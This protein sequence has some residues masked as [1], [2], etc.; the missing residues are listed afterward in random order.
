MRFSKKVSIL[1]LFVPCIIIDILT[2]PIVMINLILTGY[3]LRPL[4]Q[5]LIEQEKN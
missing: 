3:P 4:T 5:D 1:L 2:L